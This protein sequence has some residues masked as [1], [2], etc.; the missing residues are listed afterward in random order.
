MRSGIG[1]VGPGIA[2]S[3]ASGSRTTGPRTDRPAARASRT[4]CGGTSRMDGIDASV[5]S[6]SALN[7]SVSGAIAA[8]SKSAGSKPPE[9]FAVMAGEDSTLARERQSTRFANRCRDAAASAR[10]GVQDGQTHDLAVLVA[11]DDV[12]VREL[13]VG[14]LRRL[15]ELD[16]EHVCFGVIRRGEEPV[17]GAQDDRDEVEVGAYVSGGHSCFLRSSAGR[18]RVTNAVITKPSDAF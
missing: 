16:V 7:R 1:P 10:A 17:R 2:R 6:R 11:D 8:G 18:R 15:F 3:S 5:A 13:A 4:T 12:V 14:R 9:A